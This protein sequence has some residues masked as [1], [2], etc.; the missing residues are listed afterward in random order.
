MTCDCDFCR[1]GQP[2]AREQGQQD[3]A[4]LVAALDRMTAERDAA[5]RQQTDLEA[6]V[7]YLQGML[8]QVGDTLRAIRVRCPYRLDVPGAWPCALDAGHVGPHT[9]RH[10][11]QTHGHW[12]E[13]P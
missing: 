6:R 8:D 10:G 1:D 3:E 12:E 13:T 2:C 4:A 9:D 7:A 5:K 11:Q